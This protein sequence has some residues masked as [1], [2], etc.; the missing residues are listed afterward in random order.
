[1]NRTKLV[2]EEEAEGLVEEIY[3]G[4]KKDFGGVPNLFKALAVKPGILKAN[5]E[6]VKSIMMTGDLDRTLKEMVAVVVSEANGCDY[7]VGAHSAFL[8]QLGVKEETI[9]EVLTDIDSAD[10][11]K[12]RKKILNF[13][14]QST[15]NPHQISDAEFNQIKELGF[16]DAEIVE[17]VSVIDL[18]TSFNIFLDTLEVQLDL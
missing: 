15:T 11:S 14:V 12:K 18:F 16:T 9:N 10:I 17:L 1:M 6:K 5:L 7:C 8:N 3:G 13:A 4:I 2:S